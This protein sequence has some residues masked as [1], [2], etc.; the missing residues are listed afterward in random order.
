MENYGDFCGF[1]FNG[2]HS[3]TLGIIRVSDGSRYN[4]TVI[5]NFQDKT[6]QVPG[7][8]ETYFFK[9]DYQQKPISIKVAFDSMTEVQYRKF[10]QV[11]N[12]KT[13]GYLIFDEAPYK[14]YSAKLQNPP[15]LNTVCFDTNSGRVYK[16]EGAINFICY[17]PLAI[18]VHKFLD[19]Y[20]GDTSGWAAASGMKATQGTYDGTG[21]AINL[22]N[23]GD[24]ST[25]WIAYYA[26]SSGTCALNKVTIDGTHMLQFSQFYAQGTTT[27]DAYIG[28]NSRTQLIEGYSSSFDRTGY[29]YNG[30][31]TSGD[32]FKIPLGESTF[33]SYGASCS[34][35]TYNYLYY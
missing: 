14:Q 24:L 26:F 25:D 34:K 11:F 33:H 2:T 18:S 13:I 20:T 6:V 27:P 12:G 9:T 21:T 10:R 32:F 8:D 5:P 23:A 17:N 16:G 4:D 22:Y 29:I 15:Q 1:T 7:V 35:I 30:N 31:I 28:I 3:T 19:E